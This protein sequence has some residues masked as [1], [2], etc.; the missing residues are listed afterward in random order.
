MLVAE[1]HKEVQG[2]DALLQKHFGNEWE[3]AKRVMMCESGGNPTRHNP[4]PPDD[5]WG[6]FQINRYGKLA[7]SRP[8]AEWL[9][10][11]ENNIQYAAGIWRAQGW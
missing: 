2:W 10:V 4:L 5:S 9:V 7:A 6:L 1:A 3:N 8:S 11:G